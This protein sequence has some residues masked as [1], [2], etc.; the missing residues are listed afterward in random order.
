VS[1][2]SV[3]EL[4][5]DK[6]ASGESIYCPGRTNGDRLSDN[7]LSAQQAY[8]IGIKGTAFDAPM[9]VTEPA[10]SH[11]VRLAK[12]TYAADCNHLWQRAATSDEVY[13]AC[14]LRLPMKAIRGFIGDMHEQNLK[15]RQRVAMLEAERGPGLK[16]EPK[17]ITCDVGAYWDD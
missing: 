12:E 17:P 1:Q 13:C 10:K 15:L 5:S 9:P 7:E 2:C 3:C 16:A 4:R 14:G 8:A 6:R 11:Y